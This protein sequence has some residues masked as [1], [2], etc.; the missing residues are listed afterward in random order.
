MQ[1]IVLASASPQR[2]RLL[3][4]LGLSFVVHPSNFDEASCMEA[5]PITRAKHLAYHKASDVAPLFPESI[6]I[7]C[8][9]LVASEK[10]ELLEKMPDADAA[11]ACMRALS[12]GVCQVHSALSVLTPDQKHHEGISS[13][14]VTF[15]TL[16]DV[17]IDWWVST[18]LW[19]DR[20]GAFQIDGP[21]Q[22]LISHL[23]GDWTGVVGLPVYL[24]GE[25]LREAGFDVHEVVNS[26]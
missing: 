4:G 15:K 8:D 17:E 7:G 19:R 24:L 2:K 12:G 18:E 16:S 26:H 5:D 14:N 23:E 25:L 10:G 13:A 21:G 22:L 1:P 11:R 20:S 3:E 6:V 9:T